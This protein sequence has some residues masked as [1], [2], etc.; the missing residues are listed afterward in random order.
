MMDG[1]VGM[2]VGDKW[3][4]RKGVRY[5]ILEEDGGRLKIGMLNKK[6]IQKM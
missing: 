5:E 3:T 6:A 4:S 1:Q 2:A